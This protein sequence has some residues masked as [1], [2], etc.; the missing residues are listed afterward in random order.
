MAHLTRTGVR[1]ATR[2]MT[3]RVDPTARGFRG[4]PKQYVFPKPP[5]KK[6]S[7]SS[8]LSG[9]NSTLQISTSDPF[10]KRLKNACDAMA[11]EMLPSPEKISLPNYIEKTL[12]PFTQEDVDRVMGLKG[13]NIFRI[14]DMDSETLLSLVK[15]AAVVREIHKYGDRDMLKIAAKGIVPVFATDSGSLRT[16]QAS[17]D[18]S[19]EILSLN[20]RVRDNPDL[21]R[22][23]KGRDQNDKSSKKGVARQSVRNVTL[24][25]SAMA[26][27]IRDLV[28]T[29]NKGG[30]TDHIPGLVYY[31]RNA[32]P[33]T[34][35]DIETGK[36]ITVR[37]HPYGVEIFEDIIK[38]TAENRLFSALCAEN[39]NETH[40]TQAMSDYATLLQNRDAI[41]SKRREDLDKIT[42]FLS[43]KNN[44]I[45]D[46]DFVF[47]K[48][49]DQV[50]YDT[51][52]N[53]ISHL[54]E[55]IKKCENI[56]DVKRLKL[57]LEEKRGIMR[58]MLE[59]ERKDLINL[60]DLITV[61]V[62][63]AGSKKGGIT[64][65]DAQT[66]S[67][68][69]FPPEKSL[70]EIILQAEQAK[71]KPDIKVIMCC[72]TKE[73]ELPLSV[74]DPSG[75]LEITHDPLARERADIINFRPWQPTNP[76]RLTSNESFTEGINIIVNTP[77]EFT[78]TEHDLY[79][80]RQGKSML[81]HCHPM[82]PEED[83][84]VGLDDRERLAEADQM[85]WRKYVVAACDLVLG[86]SREKLQPL[87]NAISSQPT[88]KH[89]AA[90][91][92]R[93][94]Y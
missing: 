36:D 72:P 74:D 57:E 94:P 82:G 46:F 17:V 21:W 11:P 2:A 31:A 12:G 84:I 81:T 53:S 71:Q 14:S 27:H 34:L 88:P 52:K 30:N 16:R 75:I 69:V 32:A 26:G 64:R 70:I 35:T 65:E 80:V 13:G 41:L 24:S 86:A 47:R 78:L 56:Q 58:S 77:K 29:E 59:N 54:A 1:A 76:E 60:G 3:R 89:P 5:H 37:G 7:A 33:V 19:E 20:A 83:L 39:G 10:L 8:A 44:D 15:F 61:C 62:F 85:D 48:R 4:L 25:E 38:A 68:M 23:V 55:A 90:T 91:K 93:I 49:Y 92:P 67:G 73:F 40:T 50:N 22:G 87:L 43:N 42:E 28:E 63:W 9:K 45:S 51:F 79:K 6:P 66:V 18:A